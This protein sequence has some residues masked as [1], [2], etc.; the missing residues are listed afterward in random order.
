M[1]TAHSEFVTQREARRTLGLSIYLLTKLVQEGKIET[2]PTPAGQKLYDVSGYL[3]RL[4]AKAQAEAV[5]NELKIV[6]INALSSTTALPPLLGAIHR[7]EAV[8]AA[9]GQPA[10]KETTDADA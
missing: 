5:A 10:T 4:K 8:L 2:K 9:L 3:R 7:A 6:S 1:P